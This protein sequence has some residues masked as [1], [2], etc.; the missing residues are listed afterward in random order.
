M[1]LVLSDGILEASFFACHLWHTDVTELLF[2]KLLGLRLHCKHKT[3]TV[4]TLT[5]ANTTS[6]TL[7]TI[8]TTS[9]KTQNTYCQYNE[10]T[11]HIQSVLSSGSQFKSGLLFRS[12]QFISD[13]DIFVYLH[14]CSPLSVMRI[15]QPAGSAAAMMD[16]MKGKK[17]SKRRDNRP[18]VILSQS[19]LT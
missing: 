8:Y 19:T 7:Q 2:N 16:D 10:D 13:N 5:T 9:V 14:I 3:H 18:E 17:K 15:L 1:I 6:T 11:K 4:S 12:V